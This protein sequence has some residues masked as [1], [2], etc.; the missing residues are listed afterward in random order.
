[1]LGDLTVTCDYL[2]KL[3]AE[4]FFCREV[5]CDM[6]HIDGVQCIETPTYNMY[7]IEQL[8]DEL[9]QELRSRLVAICHGADAVS[10][11]SL[12]FTYKTTVR[13]FLNRYQSEENKSEER[14]KGMIGELLVHT[15]IEIDGKYTVA[16]PFFNMEENSFKKGYDIAL[17]E[18]SSSEL[19]ITEVKSGEKQKSQATPTK[20]IT[21]LVNKAKNDLKDRLSSSTTTLWYNAINAAK[22]SMSNNNSQKQAVITL[23]EQCGDNA[24]LNQSSSTDYNV[25]L[26]GV[27]FHPISEKADDTAI[28]KQAKRI[29]NKHL[30]RKM[31]VF[32]IQKSTYSAIADFLKSEGE[33]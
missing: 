28:E 14:K 7:F 30:F 23:L 22:V 12:L 25:I 5:E 20:T 9:K 1:M 17:F 24:V 26:A 19:W 33:D 8:T 2:S 29:S 13:S 18:P 11:S 3:D 15:L 10:S 32:A 31:L 21:D 27:A 4:Q 6:K 16:S